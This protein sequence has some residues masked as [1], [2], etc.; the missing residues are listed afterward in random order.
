MEDER[1]VAL[2]G[3]ALVLFAGR[4]LY[5]PR[6]RTLAIADLHL[7]KGDHFRRAGIALPSG[8]TGHDL[9]RLDALL[10][11]TGAARLLVLGDLLHGALPDA[12]WRERWRAFRGRHPALAVELVPGNHDRMLR[13]R[14][15]RARDLGLGRVHPPALSEPPFVFAHAPGDVPAG[16]AGYPLAGHLHPVLRLPGLPPLPAFRFGAGG[17]LPAFTA[18]AGGTPFEPAPGERVFVCAPGALVEV[19]AR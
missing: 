6:A 18:F 10:A 3:E 2:A 5:W 19:P 16:G 14:P 9:E 15:D 4:A 13:R 7:G 11:R 8:G 1:A 12:P 17:L